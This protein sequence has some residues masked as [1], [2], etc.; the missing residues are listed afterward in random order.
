MP[1]LR[2]A[3]PGLTPTATDRRRTEAADEDE[4][5]EADAVAASM[6]AVSVPVLLP[7][8][9]CFAD[10]DF[11]APRFGFRNFELN[12]MR[13]AGLLLPPAL[14]ERPRTGDG[15]SSDWS[16]VASSESSLFESSSAA[17]V[18]C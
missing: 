3:R 5:E 15:A 7:S 14:A 16:E 17:V 10:A 18:A 8:A 13:L 2:S 4:D 6:A 9:D 12:C 1:P 11:E